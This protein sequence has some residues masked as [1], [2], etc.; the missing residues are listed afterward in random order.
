VRHSS[1]KAKVAQLN[2]T[3][4]VHNWL[5]NFLVGHC[6]ELDMD[7]IHPWTGLDWV[8]LDWVQFLVKNLDW[9]GLGQKFC[10]LHCL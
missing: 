10:P 5:A 1:L 7:W 3:D 2:L 9:I 6:P 4:N 8:G